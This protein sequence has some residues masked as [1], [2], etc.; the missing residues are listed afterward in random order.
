[1]VIKVVL[2][3]LHNFRFI[4]ELHMLLYINNVLGVF[5]VVC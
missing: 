4:E 1:M 2:F 3:V 5:S